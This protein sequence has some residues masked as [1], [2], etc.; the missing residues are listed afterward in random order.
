MATAEQHRDQTGDTLLL[1]W[2]FEVLL[3][4][5]YLPDEAWA[6]A[7][8]TDVDLRLAERLL[9]QGCPSPTALRILL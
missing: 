1:G 6:L 9:A 5:G 7:S 4:A 3:E 2:R 8:R